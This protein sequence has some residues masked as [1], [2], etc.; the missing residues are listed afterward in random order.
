MSSNQHGHFWIKAVNLSQ[1][2][3]T[4]HKNQKLGTVTAIDS[5]SEHLSEWEENTPLARGSTQ[6]KKTQVLN[7]LRIDLTDSSA[8]ERD[9]LENLLMSFTEVFSEG[10]RNIEKCKLGVQHHIPVKPNTVPV[11]QPQRRIP[12]ASRDEVKADLKAMLEDGIMEKSSF[13]WA[14]PL[15]IVRKS[16]WDLRTCVDYRKL[17]TATQVS[18]YPLPNIRESLDRLADASYFTTIDMVSGYHQVEVASKDQDKTA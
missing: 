15:I 16:S 11:K 17:N 6:S 10:K 12:F 7:N 8:V 14:S 13:Q 5:M 9:K 3:I 2:P 1:S 18:S 4:L